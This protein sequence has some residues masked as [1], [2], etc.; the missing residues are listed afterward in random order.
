MGFQGF[1]LT[2]TSIY[3]G[4]PFKRLRRGR[5]ESPW[6]VKAQRQG[7][8]LDLVAV[9]AAVTA[10][11]EELIAWELWMFICPKYE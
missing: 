10:G 7:M 2:K 11:A 4:T 3:W 8:Q 5:G 6:I 1:P 9:T